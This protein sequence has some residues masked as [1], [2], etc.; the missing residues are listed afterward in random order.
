MI[1]STLFVLGQAL[2]PNIQTLLI[3]RL[4]AGVF[5]SAPLTNCGGPY[6]NISRYCIVCADDSGRAGVMADIWDP[7]RRGIAMSLFTAC[8][9]L[10][11]VLGPVVG[12]L[13]VTISPLYRRE[14]AQTCF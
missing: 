1:C 10:G 7:A 11:P 9:F 12:S 8:V 13:W 2:A 6:L 4:L 5:A 14:Y 3:T